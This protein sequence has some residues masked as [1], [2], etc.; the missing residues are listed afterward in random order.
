[1]SEYFQINLICL[2]QVEYGAKSRKGDSA[3]VLIKVVDLIIS[4]LARFCV[5]LDL[6]TELILFWTFLWFAVSLVDEGN[7][8]KDLVL[9]RAVRG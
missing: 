6:N 5:S 3:A 9:A 2:I 1:M 4:K 8:R 7:V